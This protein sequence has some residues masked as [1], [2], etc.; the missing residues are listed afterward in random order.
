MW[1]LSKVWLLFF[2]AEDQVYISEESWRYE[3]VLN[4]RGSIWI[5]SS[6]SNS[7]LA[8]NFGQVCFITPQI[9]C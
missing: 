7:G 5:G 8:W 3:Y 6:R 4:Q 1:T 2:N 9:L